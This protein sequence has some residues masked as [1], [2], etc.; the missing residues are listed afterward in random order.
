MGNIKSAWLSPEI[1]AGR[2][3]FYEGDRFTV[4]LELELED[5]DGMP[6]E[7]TQEDTVEIVIYDMPT[8][9]WEQSYTGLTENAVEL[10]VHDELG[11]LL[12][13]GEY[14]L[15]IVVHHGG[16]VTTVGEATVEVRK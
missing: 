8:V 15:R 2:L 13:A 7:L 14:E 12:S 16:T 3:R 5:Q 1:T 9:V 4:R 11:K 6:V 10:A